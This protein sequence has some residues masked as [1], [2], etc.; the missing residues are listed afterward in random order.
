MCVCVCV[1]VS[2]C[3]YACMYIKECC[4]LSSALSS[5]IPP[6]AGSSVAMETNI[7]TE[8][9]ARDNQASGQEC[10][11]KTD[12]TSSP[13]DRY[14]LNPLHGEATHSEHCSPSHLQES[15]LIDLN[16][17][18]SPHQDIRLPTSIT[19]S[20]SEQELPLAAVE[21]SQH[22][23]PSLEHPPQEHIP[24][25]MCESG[26]LQEPVEIPPSHGRLAVDP[27]VD[28]NLTMDYTSGHAESGAAGD[29]SMEESGCLQS[30]A[31]STSSTCKESGHPEEYVHGSS[32]QPADGS[33]QSGMDV[34]GGSGHQ[35]YGRFSALFLVLLLLL[36][37]SF[38]SSLLLLLRSQL[39]LWGSPF[40][41]RFFACVLF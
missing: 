13:I 17:S 11:Q 6:E 27:H 38:T 31:P 25:L 4:H 39:Y 21:H 7:L 22:P 35:Q 20:V 40:L 32:Y 18:S 36:L 15:R 5:E 19:T 23:A 30:S 1:C 34:Y 10:T 33:L 16:P 3:V 26:V 14:T 12:N 2:V 24:S 29:I 9:I 41:V 28:S 37:L 8:I